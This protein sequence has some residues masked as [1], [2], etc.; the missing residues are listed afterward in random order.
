[1][2]RG[3]QIRFQ[4]T[5]NTLLIFT[6]P[7]FPFLLLSERSPSPSARLRRLPMLCSGDT[8]TGQGARSLAAQIVAGAYSHIHSL[9]SAWPPRC[10][11]GS[12]LLPSSRML[13][14]ARL[15]QVD[16]PPAS[17]PDGLL[18][19]ALFQ[20]APQFASL[21]GRFST[22]LILLSAFRH[23]TVAPAAG[24]RVRRAG[25]TRVEYMFTKDDDAS[26]LS[27]DAQ[28]PTTP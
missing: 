18:P 5:Q 3:S 11:P 17:P 20:D 8:V 22:G 19:P 10:H 28:M 25:E 21:P 13:L 4:F 9:T 2:V 6:E 24:S 16:S 26:L 15:C 12:C 27:F 7:F 14:R 1:M 23:A